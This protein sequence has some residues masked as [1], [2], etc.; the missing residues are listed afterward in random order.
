MLQ[1]QLVSAELLP[2]DLAVA[3][4]RS[5]LAGEAQ[6]TVKV[7]TTVGKYI[8][9]RNSGFGFKSIK[10]SATGRGTLPRTCTTYI[11]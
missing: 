10:E 9:V 3:L 11:S 6:L 8:V 2:Q 5:W 4:M 7:A 1:P